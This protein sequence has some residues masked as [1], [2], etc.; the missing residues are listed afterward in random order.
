MCG[1][2]DFQHLA[3]GGYF[4]TEE[5]LEFGIAS[6]FCARSEVM[7]VAIKWEKQT[8]RTITIFVKCCGSEIR[9]LDDGS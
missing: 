2:Y 5:P 8:G 4:Y 6:A 1:V 3:K 7:S 9:S